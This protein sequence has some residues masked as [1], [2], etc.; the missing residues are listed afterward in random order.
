MVER[1]I[2]VVNP[3]GLHTRPGHKFIAEAKKHSCDI[4]VQKG[5]KKFSAKSLLKL[6]K[7]GISQGDLIKIICN[8]EGENAALENMC[9]FVANLKD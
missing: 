9:E 6:M 5:D 8:G 3:T 4:F 7:I 2:Q 1:E